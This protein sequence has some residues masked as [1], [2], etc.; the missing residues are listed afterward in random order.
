M[1]KKYQSKTF[2]LFKSMPSFS[3]GISR[4]FD[5]TGIINENNYNTS[6]TD[7]EAD[8][9]ALKGDWEVVGNDLKTAIKNYDKE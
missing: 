8:F 9:N 4:A 2:G 5:L 1:E 3:R 7:K 6:K